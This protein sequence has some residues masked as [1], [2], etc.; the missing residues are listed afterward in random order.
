MS[1]EY[2]AATMGTP[3]EGP[4]F[5]D[6]PRWHVD[7][8]V[9]LPERRGVQAEGMGVCPQPTPRREHRLLHHFPDL[10]GDQE[11]AFP[12]WEPRRLDEQEIAPLRSP[13]EATATPGRLVR[14]ASSVSMW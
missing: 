8:Q 11:L 2:S 5:G 13:G 9:A 3:A 1:S 7:V 14:S 10:T 6:R 4:S 12:L